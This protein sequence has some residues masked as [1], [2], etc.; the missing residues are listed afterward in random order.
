MDKIV[1]VNVKINGEHCSNLVKAMNELKEIEKLTSLIDTFGFSQHEV[2]SIIENASITL[3]LLKRIDDALQ[4]L[5]NHIIRGH[6][7][8]CLVSEITDILTGA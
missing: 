6:G 2:M 4:L 3:P 5:G 8:E 1:T 7:G